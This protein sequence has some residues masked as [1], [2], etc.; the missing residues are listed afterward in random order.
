MP[1]YGT[2]THLDQREPVLP[3][4]DRFV[5][6]AVIRFAG[7]EPAV[8]AGNSLGGCAAL[9]AAENEDLG[10]AAVV[11]IAPAGFDMAGWIGLIE[12][13]WL[14]RGLLTSPLPLPERVVR[15]AVG[16]VY[17]R[18]AFARPRSIDGRIVSAFTSHVSA[19]ADVA[20]ILASGRRLRPELAD[21]FDLERVSCPVLIVWGDSDR[22]VYASGAER[23]LRE[24]DGARLEVI[25]E[26]GHC[27]QIE[28]PERLVELIEEFAGSAEAAAA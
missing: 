28:A 5:R 20:R 4:L 23:V 1:G 16:Q 7:G 10:L 12:G 21:P 2:A 15:G 18:V 6:A 13:E 3:Q 9:R 27:P 11:P 17:R 24:V 14:I 26:C 22:M 25:E 8:I 19:R